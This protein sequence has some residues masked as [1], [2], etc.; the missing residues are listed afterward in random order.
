MVVAFYH[1][2]LKA[3][4][5]LSR[6]VLSGK[7]KA[8]HNVVEG[9]REPASSYHRSLSKPSLRQAAG[10]LR[11]WLIRRHAN[12]RGGCKRPPRRFQEM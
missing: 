10:T 3:E 8:V 6:L 5:D 4:D 1:E 9:F 7:L 12:A 2:R 11:R